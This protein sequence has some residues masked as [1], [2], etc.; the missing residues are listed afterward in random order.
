MPHLTN[1]EQQETPIIA[2][3]K[4]WQRIK[5]LLNNNPKPLLVWIS[6]TPPQAINDA[7]YQLISQL[8][9][10]FKHQLLTFP[11]QGVVSLYRYLQEQIPNDITQN[12]PN[13]PIIHISQIDGHTLPD[14]TGRAN[15][16][17]EE[18]NFQRELLFRQLPFHLI[19]WASEYSTLQIKTHALDF[20]H[21]VNY[22]FELK[23]STAQTQNY[24]QQIPDTSQTVPKSKSNE[25]IALLNQLLDDLHQL[26]HHS[27][28]DLSNQ[29]NQISALKL[30]G[31]VY[32]EIGEYPKAIKHYKQALAII[33]KLP[34]TT[35]RHIASHYFDMA[36]LA[37]TTA[38]YQE[39]LDYYEKCRTIYEQILPP[40]HPN[41]AG[42]YLNM[43]VTY[44]S[45]TDYATALDY[46]EKCRTIYEQ[47]LPPLN[48]DLAD[49]YLNMGNAYSS[50]TDYATALDYYE[51]CRTIY[52][53]I[54]PPKRPNLA[55]LYLNAGNTYQ[56]LTDY[57][58]ALNYYEKCRTIYEQILPS[59]HPDLAML[60]MNIGNT[61]NGLTDYAIA[62]NYYEKCRTIY[63]QI[64]PP[65]HPNLAMLYMN[66]GITYDSLTDYVTALSY[67]EKCRT[68]REQILPP[69]HPDLAMLY[70]NIGIL[71]AQQTQWQKAQIYANKGVDIFKAILPIKHP[72]LQQALQIQR[73]I[74]Q[75]S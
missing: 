37:N 45:L 36:L 4:Q 16:F 23:Y 31:N 67:Y 24:A 38:Q 15:P 40:L 51:K 73:D 63:E 48:A 75:F 47:I 25:Q 56:S 49:L 59:L 61:Y 44:D 17:V 42:L 72:H 30:I 19:I 41:L 13:L 65:L 55:A 6:V 5:F 70:L 58:T 2:N 53:Q 12:A 46:Y 64:L 21:W 10:T 50:L 57:A 14:E 62:L 39:A 27:E 71:Y 7:Q 1:P 18:L 26:T 8:H 35:Q 32:A 11:A 29:R 74:Q 33:E 9:P 43:G 68:I 60:Y 20:W 22:H 28:N 3:E 54:L 69:Q 34:N 52:E 66:M